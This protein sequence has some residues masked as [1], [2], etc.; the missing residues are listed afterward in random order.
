M[1]SSTDDPHGSPPAPPAF[2]VAVVKGR[3]EP[4]T[5]SLLV[6]KDPSLHGPFLEACLRTDKESKG[7]RGQSLGALLEC[8]TDLPPDVFSRPEFLRARLR[9]PD[10]SEC[11]ALWY[12]IDRRLGGPAVDTILGACEKEASQ[13]PDWARPEALMLGKRAGGHRTA[14]ESVLFAA[15]R[16]GRWDIFGRVLVVPGAPKLSAEEIGTADLRAL[17]MTLEAFGREYGRPDSER[18][19]GLLEELEAQL[20]EWGGYAAD[21]PDLVE[22]MLQRLPIGFLLGLEEEGQARLRELRMRPAVEL[23][24]CACF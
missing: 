24:A 21:N 8:S 11:S 13:H 15:A 4:R 3:S 10:G 14:P 6:P 20:R 18:R 22:K 16:S 9:L 12:A 17:E 1:G 2:W 23:A 5:A 19:G 7:P